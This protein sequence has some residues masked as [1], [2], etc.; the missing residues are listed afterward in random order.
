M[1]RNV[2][3][4]IESMV[5][6]TFCTRATTAG[7]ARHKHERLCP[8]NKIPVFPFTLYKIPVFPFT[9][10]SYET[11]YVFYITGNGFDTF[12]GNTPSFFFFFT[13]NSDG[14]YIPE[15]H[16]SPSP[17]PFF[18]YQSTLFPFFFLRSYT[19]LFFIDLPAFL[20]CPH[21]QR[22]VSP[23]HIFFAQGFVVLF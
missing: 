14:T 11:S 16:W 2:K 19:C 8:T 21:H 9:L 5:R 17:P 22:S 20:C 1:E 7:S 15:W 6:R 3:A 4:N 18:L 23:P 10:F 12:A 13:A